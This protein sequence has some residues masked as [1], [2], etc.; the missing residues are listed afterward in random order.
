MASL[1]N[2][3]SSQSNPVFK[4]NCIFIKTQKN[5]FLQSNINISIIYINDIISE[6]IKALKSFELS[7]MPQV[8]AFTIKINPDNQY[9]N[10]HEIMSIIENKVIKRSILLEIFDEQKHVFIHNSNQS[11]D[12][13]FWNEVT[14]TQNELKNIEKYIPRNFFVKVLSSFKDIPF[15]NITKDELKKVIH[16]IKEQKIYSN[17]I[18]SRDEID[19]RF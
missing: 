10:F 17:A 18:R 12:G 14:M 16:Y 5:S 19:V 4:K 8:F 1:K 3:F 13:A 7:H 9:Q 15:V 2:L 11:T 6:V